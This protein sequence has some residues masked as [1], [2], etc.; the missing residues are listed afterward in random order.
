MNM[1]Y[2][3][4]L[5]ATFCFLS[6]QAATAV[7]SADGQLPK[8][9][10]SGANGYLG[11][12]ATRLLLAQGV[13]PQNLILVTRSVD[14][15]RNMSERGVSV[16][17]GDFDD[18]TSLP[19]AFAGG[20]RLLLISTTESGPKL[21]QQNT[22]A[23]KA[24]GTVGIRYIVYTSMVNAKALANYVLAANYATEQALAASGIEWT[25]Q[26]D[27]DYQDNLLDSGAVAI[28][29]GQY[30]TNTGQG[31][32]AS[33][34]RDDCAAVAAALLLKPSHINRAIEVTG[35]ELLSSDDVAALLSE[36]SG[37]PVR[38][39]SIDDAMLGARLRNQHVP[40]ELTQFLIGF[41]K[42]RREGVF[43]VKTSIVKTITG[44]EPM[45][46]RDFVMAHR[47]QLLTAAVRRRPR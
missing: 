41:G 5:A 16:R 46:M 40:A 44:H 4:I 32:A 9:V 21:L 30:V 35:P 6:G 37:K 22:A 3:A 10:I 7:N 15:L 23:I 8:I 2:R 11:R 14:N 42:A 19:A 12:E 25:A 34:S 28:A 47:A 26:R 18:P 17:R 31:K 27:Q 24:A 38:A 33:V 29:T 39:V 20:T 13:L 1:A 36:I 43:A 45:A